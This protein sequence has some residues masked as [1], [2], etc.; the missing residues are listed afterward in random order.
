LLLLLP[1]FL[2]LAFIE[3]WLLL[4]ALLI[5]CMAYPL[6]TTPVEIMFAKAHLQ[7]AITDFTQG[8]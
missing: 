5:T 4:P 7:Q 3:G 8:E 1:V 2:S 6:L